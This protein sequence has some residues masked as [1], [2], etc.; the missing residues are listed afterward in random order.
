MAAVIYTGGLLYC[1]RTLPSDGQAFGHPVA[2]IAYR[3]GRLFCTCMTRRGAEEEGVGG[4]RKEEGGV[5]QRKTKQAPHS[6]WGKMQIEDMSQEFGGSGCAS[7][8][9]VGTS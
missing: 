4:R 1:I 9:P 2:S 7:W 5:G 8:V 3:D 6:R